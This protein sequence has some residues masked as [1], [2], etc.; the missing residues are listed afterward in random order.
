MP[1]EHEVT[2]LNPVWRTL[3]FTGLTFPAASIIPTS[4]TPINPHKSPGGC[5]SWRIRGACRLRK[6]NRIRFVC[7]HLSLVKPL[8][9]GKMQIS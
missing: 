3:D 1:P 5:K 6:H 8:V 9:I 4:K 2:G 7:F